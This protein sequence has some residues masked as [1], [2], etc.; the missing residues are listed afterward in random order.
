MY[1][2]HFALDRQPSGKTNQVDYSLYIDI[3]ELMINLH[4]VDERLH[5]THMQFSIERNGIERS[6]IQIKK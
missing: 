1:A 5:N 4:V 2:R 6:D 3:N